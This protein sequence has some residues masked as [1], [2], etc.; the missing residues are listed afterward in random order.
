MNNIS[1][2]NSQPLSDA[3]PTVKGRKILFIDRD[4]VLIKEAPPTYQLDSFDK[5]EFY[6]NVFKY[7]RKIATELNFE[8]VMVTNQDGL[9]T[10]SFPENTFWPLHNLVINSL[11]NEGIVQ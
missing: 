1:Q 5:L 2:S 11:A 6:P 10:P 4:G 7:L 9:G 3:N 8:L